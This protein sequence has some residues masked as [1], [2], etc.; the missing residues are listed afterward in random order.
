MKPHAWRGGFPDLP[1]KGLPTTWT[2]VIKVNGKIEGAF[3]KPAHAYVNYVNGEVLVKE[4]PIGTLLMV[5]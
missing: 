1:R 3:D 4:R 2:P 5:R